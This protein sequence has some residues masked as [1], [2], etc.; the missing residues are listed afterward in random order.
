MI[1]ITRNQLAVIYRA[2]K[3]GK[4]P[5]VSNADISNMYKLLSP[6]HDYFNS[7]DYVYCCSAIREAVE[8]ILKGDANHADLLL[9]GFE[10]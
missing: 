6:S 2:F 5:Q 1:R 10:L 9:H 4:L 8:D 3:E 7:K